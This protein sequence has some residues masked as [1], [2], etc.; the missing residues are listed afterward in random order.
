MKWRALGQ[1]LGLSFSKLQNLAK[2]YEDDSEECYRTLLCK[3]FTSP[4][5]DYPVTWKGLFELLVD[6]H[7]DDVVSELK[8]ALFKAEAYLT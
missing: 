7:L 3:W 4:P 2:A 1:L 5:P 8:T 6:S